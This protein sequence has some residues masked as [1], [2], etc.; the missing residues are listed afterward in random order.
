MFVEW[1]RLSTLQK[2]LLLQ[3]TCRH[4]YFYNEVENVYKFSINSMFSLYQRQNT[5]AN[6]LFSVTFIVSHEF[7]MCSCIL[8]CLIISEVVILEE[9]V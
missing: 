4:V 6:D 1:A 8:L 5:I 3:K 2:Q 9:A 7:N